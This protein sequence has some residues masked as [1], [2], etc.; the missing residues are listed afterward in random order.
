MGLICKFCIQIQYINIQMRKIKYN[1]K[2]I[3]KTVFL[4]KRLLFSDSLEK[5]V[6]LK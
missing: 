2:K 4:I 3:K 6:V 5:S 1:A